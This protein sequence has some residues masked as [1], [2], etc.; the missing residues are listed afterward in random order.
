MSQIRYRIQ[1]VSQM[2]GIP[3]ATL[4]AWERR[5]GFPEPER[6]QSSYRLYSEQDISGQ[7]CNI[8]Q[9]LLIKYKLTYTTCR[10]QFIS[11]NENFSILTNIIKIIAPFVINVRNVLD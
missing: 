9:I 5:Y 8:A 3:A 10:L 7:I 6:T 4:R 11:L 2:T 1:T